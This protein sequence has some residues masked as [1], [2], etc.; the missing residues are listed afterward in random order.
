MMAR[1][2]TVGSYGFGSLGFAFLTLGLL[3]GGQKLAMANVSPLVGDC[4]LSTSACGA[5]TCTTAA[6]D[7]T[8]PVN[9]CICS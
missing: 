1:L 7:C 3:L 9:N 2:S 5:G 8:D 4:Q 6:A